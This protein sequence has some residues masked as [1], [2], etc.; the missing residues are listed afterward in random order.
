[1][2]LPPPVSA[3]LPSLAID[4]DG[5]ALMRFYYLENLMSKFLASVPVDETWYLA[6]YP[7]LRDAHE[8]G[9]LNLSPGEHYRRRGY[10][11]GRLP[12]APLVD[13]E[14]YK[15]KYPD[16]AN[17]IKEGKLQSAYE[18]FVHCGYREDRDPT[19]LSSEQAHQTPEAPMKLAKKS[20]P[21]FRRTGL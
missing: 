11:E 7:D 2:T 21:S 18:H 12:F 20:V 9:T 3:I 14:A 19:P 8:R 5:N 6:Q 1:M 4:D 16:V 10:L 13:E 17:D 15:A